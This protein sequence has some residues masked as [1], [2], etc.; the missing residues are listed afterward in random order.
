VGVL[1][2]DSLRLVIDAAPI[3]PGLTYEAG[4]QFIVSALG[5]GTVIGVLAAL[6]RIGRG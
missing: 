3:A 6:T 1:H 4:V 2:V 5:V